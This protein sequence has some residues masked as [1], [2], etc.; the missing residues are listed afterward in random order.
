MK[1]KI[2]EGEKQTDFNRHNESLSKVNSNFIRL[3]Q[4]LKYLEWDSAPSEDSNQ[5]SCTSMCTQ[6]VSGI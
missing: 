6:D 5:M 3:R 2:G 4:D 1:N